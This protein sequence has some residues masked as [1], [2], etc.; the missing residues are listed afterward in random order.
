VPAEPRNALSTGE[1]SWV[2]QDRVSSGSSVGGLTSQIQTSGCATARMLEGPRPMPIP[3]AAR[4]TSEFLMAEE[5]TWV[6]ALLKLLNP[7]NN[8]RD[9][10]TTGHRIYELEECGLPGTLDHLATWLQLTPS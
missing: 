3:A 5:P 4:L 9:A 8:W 10:P 7:L 1:R 2:R 6:A